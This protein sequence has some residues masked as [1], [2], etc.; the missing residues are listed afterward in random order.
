[1]FPPSDEYNGNHV[2]TIEELVKTKNAKE[3]KKYK[4]EYISLHTLT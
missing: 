4:I 2:G 3:K 1:M